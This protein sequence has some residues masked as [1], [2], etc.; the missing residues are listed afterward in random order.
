MKNIKTFELFGKKSHKNVDL[1]TSYLYDNGFGERYYIC[2][3][4]DSYKLKRNIKGGM[5]PP[6]YKCDNCGQMNYAPKSMS[7]E[8]YEEYIEDV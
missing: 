6:D 5:T 4:C 3:N 7:P 1:N 2:S 8:E